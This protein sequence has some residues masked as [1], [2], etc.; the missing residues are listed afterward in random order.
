MFRNPN[1]VGTGWGPG[2]HP[3]PRLPANHRRNHRAPTARWNFLPFQFWNNSAATLFCSAA[4]QPFS[5]MSLLCILRKSGSLSVATSDH[6]RGS[7]V[8]SDK[9]YIAC[10]SNTVDSL[11]ESTAVDKR[12]Q[13][14]P[15]PHAK[16]SQQAACASPHLTTM[17]TWLKPTPTLS[18]DGQTAAK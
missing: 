18:R 10:V 7:L 5:C 16:H 11:P 3:A 17:H 12:V 13:E 9:E 6:C 8:N 14:G 4:S 2:H 1:W 15:P